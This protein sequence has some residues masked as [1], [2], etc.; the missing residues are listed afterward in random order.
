MLFVKLYT[1]I[2]YRIR[3]VCLY[4]IE[5]TN[6]GEEAHGISQHEKNVHRLLFNVGVLYTRGADISSLYECDLPDLFKR[7][8]PE[9]YLNYTQ[10]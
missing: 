5:Y 2:L 8:L 4:C 3:A 1:M 7:A 9:S 10:R 6:T